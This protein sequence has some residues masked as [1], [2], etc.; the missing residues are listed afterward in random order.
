MSAMTADTVPTE[1]RLPTLVVAAAVGLIGGAA[2]SLIAFYLA[3]YGPSAGNWSFRGNGALAA[4]SLVPVLLTTGWCA[5]VLRA[6]GYR[7]WLAIGVGAGV[8][9]L[10]VASADAALLPLFGT[11]ADAKLGWPLLITLVA[12]MFAAPV[13]AALIRLDAPRRSV[14]AIDVASLGLWALCVGS[15]AYLAGLAFPP[16]S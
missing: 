15:G 14:R 12:W 4:Y 5:L 11:G 10:I 6:R 7:A 9:S 3:R 16:G 2:V 1:R 8:I 13:V